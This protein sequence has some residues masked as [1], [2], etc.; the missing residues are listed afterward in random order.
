MTDSSQPL[1]EL[2]GGEPRLREV[3]ED[4]YGRVFDDV[5]IGFFFKGKDRAHLVQL[6]LEFALRFLGADVAYTGRPLPEAHASHRIMGGQFN[7]RLQIL[8]ETLAHHKL[9]SA[10]VECWIEHTQSLRHQITPDA[11]GECYG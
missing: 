5:M 4:F 7:R 9:P 1:F 10:V 6:E 8:R 2:A 11:A 3:I